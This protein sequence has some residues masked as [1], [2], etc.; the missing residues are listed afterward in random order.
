MFILHPKMYV[1][2]SIKILG[3][4]NGQILKLKDL[5]LGLWGRGLAISKGIVIG[6]F[7]YDEQFGYLKTLIGRFWG[8]VMVE[9][10]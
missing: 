7:R 3:V 6:P 1:Y 2:I 4:N 5:F 8:K 10:A 9:V